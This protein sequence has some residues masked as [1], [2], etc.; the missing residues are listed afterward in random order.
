MTFTPSQ[1]T[2]GPDEFDYCKPSAKEAIVWIRSLSD[3][4]LREPRALV[5]EFPINTNREWVSARCAEE[6]YDRGLIDVIELLWPSW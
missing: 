1:V 3:E 2:H 6:L 4:E 5:T